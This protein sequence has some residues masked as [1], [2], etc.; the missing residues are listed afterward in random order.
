MLDVL[1]G[2]RPYLEAAY[3]AAGIALVVG[4]FVTR[5]QL[6][7]FRT[8][9]RLRNERL[10]K[11]KAIDAASRYLHDFVE[12]ASLDW[13]DR[14]QEKAKYYSNEIGDF[15]L[16]SLT[17]ERRLVAA[18]NMLDSKTYLPVLNELEAIASFFVTGVADEKT[19]FTIIGRSFCASVHNYYDL[20]AILRGDDRA[21]P[22]WHN[23]VELYL[24]WAP[25]LA[26]AEL[27]ATAESIARNISGLPADRSIP[28]LG[29]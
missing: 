1:T 22:Y 15:S 11:E 19:G 14:E 25:R 24:L 17:K 8:E 12:K 23:I 6:L 27:G 16:S 3:F 5:A 9:T 29:Y 20:I 21:Q 10:A 13:V 7:A 26:R 4:L 28:T 2:M 18:K